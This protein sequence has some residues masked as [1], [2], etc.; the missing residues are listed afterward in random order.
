[1][2]NS[3]NMPTLPNSNAGTPT[4]T[5]PSVPTSIQP[6]ANMS[7]TGGSGM[8]AM[9]QMQEINL[10]AQ[11]PVNTPAPIPAPQVTPT[12]NQN[13]PL[14]GGSGTGMM[15]EDMD[16]FP[17]LATEP[18]PVNTD[19]IN[20]SSEVNTIDQSQAQQQV[21]GSESGIPF[22]PDF[23]Q[24]E[25]YQFQVMTPEQIAAR[26]AQYAPVVQPQ[27]A[28]TPAQTPAPTPVRGR[29]PV[30]Q[31]TT[32]I[33]NPPVNLV[34]KQ[35]RSNPWDQDK[36]SNWYV[37][38]NDEDGFLEFKKSNPTIPNPN[39]KR[40]GKGGTEEQ[41]KQAHLRAIKNAQ[42][43]MASFNSQQQKQQQFNRNS[44]ANLNSLAFGGG[45]D[46]FALNNAI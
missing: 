9:E 10:P 44:N 21:F 20:P 11:Q 13:I 22:N 42:E 36:S 5:P 18:T 41:Y 38:K 40:W 23:Q 12:V 46:P 7:P 37:P 31:P 2:W 17:S 39:A 34:P 1:M 6:A 14:S 30:V 35:G 43:R 24:P 4:V 19:V 28:T 3:G 45:V 29:R 27:V 25:M 8:G 16:Q 15:F 26:N 33:V 32:T